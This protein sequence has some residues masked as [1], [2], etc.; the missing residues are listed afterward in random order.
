MMVTSAAWR[1][2]RNYL[3]CVSARRKHEASSSTEVVFVRILLGLIRLSVAFETERSS[4]FGLFLFKNDST[5][6]GSLVNSRRLGF[7]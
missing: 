3:F 5:W 1:C 4:L 7:R 6:S 2:V